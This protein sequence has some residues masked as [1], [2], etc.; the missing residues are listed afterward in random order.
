MFSD[1][2]GRGAPRVSLAIHLFIS[3]R[4]VTRQCNT[5]TVRMLLFGNCPSRILSDTKMTHLIP[6][7]LFSPSPSDSRDDRLFRKRR[8]DDNQVLLQFISFQAPHLAFSNDIVQPLCLQ[9][10]FLI[11]HQLSR[12][13]SS[14]WQQRGLPTAQTLP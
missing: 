12:V 6:P 2:G 10:S 9:W 7:T 13:T 3:L 1:S 5:Q 14:Q 4:G 8:G 11:L